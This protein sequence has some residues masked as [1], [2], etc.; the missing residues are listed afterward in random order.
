M[1][2]RKR[3]LKRVIVFLIAAIFVAAGILVSILVQKNQPEVVSD[4]DSIALQET[5][6]DAVSEAEEKAIKLREKY[7][8]NTVKIIETKDN[9]TLDFVGDVSLADNWYIAPKY[10]S[11]GGISGILGDSMLEEMK[12]ATVM[13][14]NSEFT[15]SNRGTK[16]SGKTYTF[17]AKPERLKIYDEMGVDLVS[18][19]N[20]H[21]YDFGKDAFMDMLDSFEEYEIPH[22]G[23]GRNLDEAKTPFFFIINSKSYAF[24][25]TTRAEKNILTPGATKNSEGVFRCYDPTEAINLIKE[26]HENKDVDYI[27]PMVHFGRENS[28]ELEDVQVSTAKKFIDAGADIIIGHHAHVLQGFEFY[29][30]KLIVYNLGNFLFNEASVDTMLFQ[31]QMDDSGKMSYKVFPALQQNEKTSLVNGAKKSQIIQDL[32]SWSVNAKID[33]TGKIEKK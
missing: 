21:V 29:K 28:H 8:K 27:I 4:S 1:S 32:N 30:D 12:S 7:G 23:A 22:V 31:L 3:D 33:S 5:Q 16:M 18:L 9:I 10:D 15:V 20:N 26:L 6:A 24:F 14:A 11:R 2:R 25:G 19:A 17:R 13:V